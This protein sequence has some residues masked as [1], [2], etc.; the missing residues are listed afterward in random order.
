MSVCVL[1]LALLQKFLPVR[2]SKYQN[3]PEGFSAAT[4]LINAQSI[5]PYF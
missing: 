4:R 3:T 1:E 2:S 5:I